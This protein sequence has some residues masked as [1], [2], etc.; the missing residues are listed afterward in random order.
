MPHLKPFF[1]AIL[2]VYSLS[3]WAQGF[4]FVGREPD[5]IA[6]AKQMKVAKGVTPGSPLVFESVSAGVVQL[7]PAG[8]EEISTLERPTYLFERGKNGAYVFFEISET[9][10]LS[11]LDRLNSIDT[12]SVA[13]KAFESATVSAFLE[14]GK[15]LRECIPSATGPKLE[16]L[17]IYVVISAGGALER[18]TVQPE[19]SVAQCILGKA[20]TTGY[21]GE[22]RFVA[23][24]KISVTP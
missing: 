17:T 6:D 22:A 24:A 9:K 1:A 20:P 18:A 10:Y 15:I 3:V 7:R 14:S 13:G 19:G 21:G 12:T 4:A 11:E 23:K 8:A 16:K 5:F 2:S